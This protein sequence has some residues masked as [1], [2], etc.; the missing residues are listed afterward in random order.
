VGIVI[1]LGAILVG[2]PTGI[3]A[4]PLFANFA[5]GWV[6]SGSAGALFLARNQPRRRRTA[7]TRSTVGPGP[8]LPAVLTTILLPPAPHD[9]S[10]ASRC[11]PSGAKFSEKLDRL[12]RRSNRCNLLIALFFGM[13]ALEFRRG[14]S[15]GHLDGILNKSLGAIAAVAGV[16]NLLPGSE[17]HSGSGKSHNSRRHPSRDF[18]VRRQGELPHYFAPARQKHH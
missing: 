15:M 9:V 11:F 6:H 18:E 17:K 14:R 8:S 1:G 13:Y 3:L 5:A 7:E 12:C 16:G 2:I 10:L 4:G